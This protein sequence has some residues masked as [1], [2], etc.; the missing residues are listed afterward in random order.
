MNKQKNNKYS[1][2]ASQEPLGRFAT[3]VAS[4]LIGKNSPDYIPHRDNDNRVVITNYD[5][6]IITGKKIEQKVYTSYSGYPGGL[7]K[8]KMKV[9]MKDN[10][11]KIIYNAIS[12]MLPKNKLRQE[13]LN[14]ISF[15]Q[16]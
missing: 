12:R 15:K 1:F 8:A 9:L 4:I 14:R 7:K 5:K 16:N 11:K 10:P 6:L 13:R 3:K 2:D